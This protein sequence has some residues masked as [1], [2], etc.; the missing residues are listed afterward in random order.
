[1]SGLVLG[2][3]SS[4]FI[5]NNIRLHNLSSGCCRRAQLVTLQK[6][7]FDE[8]AKEQE[9]EKF[10]P[11]CSGWVLKGF[12]EHCELKMQ[13]ECVHCSAQMFDFIPR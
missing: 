9:L 5:T 11:V 7:D 2:G 1:M 4:I 12:P 6:Q 3:C 13:C 10:L 8:S